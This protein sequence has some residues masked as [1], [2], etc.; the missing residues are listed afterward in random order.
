M[1][2]SK[3]T[4][5]PSLEDGR[6]QDRENAVNLVLKDMQRF[7][8]AEI[9]PAT[10]AAMRDYM[11]TKLSRSPTFDE[12][13]IRKSSIEILIKD[14]T[15][16]LHNLYDHA[17]VLLTELSKGQPAGEAPLHTYY[18]FSEENHYRVLKHNAALE[19]QI[20]QCDSEHMTLRTRNQ[21]LEESLEFHQDMLKRTAREREQA[22]RMIRQRDHELEEERKRSKRAVERAETE[23]DRA[24]RTA[25]YLFP[26]LHDLETR[27]REAEQLYESSKCS[28]GRVMNRRS[29]QGQ[30]AAVREMPAS[31]GIDGRSA[32]ASTKPMAEHRQNHES[33]QDKTAFSRS[34]SR[35]AK[36][37][38][39]SDRLDAKEGEN[40]YVTTE[41]K[42]ERKSPSDD[43]S[44]ENPVSARQVI[45]CVPLMP[46]KAMFRAGSSAQEHDG[47]TPQKTVSVFLVWIGRSSMLI[48]D[49][50]DNTAPVDTNES[51]ARLR[52][53]LRS[54]GAARPT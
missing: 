31:R 22:R 9:D 12:S 49:E 7:L 41:D 18:G 53:S 28:A 2:Q 1:A 24:N 37:F 40:A 44:V 33:R 8:P 23:R 10:F 45:P 26:Q 6:R 43:S 19:A 48:N 35:F 34:A 15:E 3:H 16:R 5:F 52:M 46:P 38:E 51:P 17:H 20:V 21:L 4:G 32:G 14:A 42:V 11:V 27:L 54:T 25:D 30:T 47:A 36:Y 13:F 50:K 29:E 39:L